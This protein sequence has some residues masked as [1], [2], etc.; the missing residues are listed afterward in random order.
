MDD[1]RLDAILRQFARERTIPSETLVRRTKATIRG[2]RLL[3]GVVF[4]SM[5]MQLVTVGWI[6]S[7]LTSPEVQTAAKLFGAISLFAYI[8]CLVV[9]AIAA[10]DKVIWFFKRVERLIA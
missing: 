10:R 2:R 1:N 8:G 6:V 9:L 7:M 3:Q 5:C 4:L